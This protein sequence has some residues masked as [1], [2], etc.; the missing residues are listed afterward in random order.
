M[1]LFCVGEKS[2]LCELACW[3]D[4][5]IDEISGIEK[6]LLL[7]AQRSRDDAQAMIA[8]KKEGV[9]QQIQKLLTSRENNAYV[10]LQKATTGSQDKEV[11]IGIVPCKAKLIW[12]QLSLQARP[13]MQGTTCTNKFLRMRSWHCPCVC[14]SA[15]I[16]HTLN[17]IWSS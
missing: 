5:G 15:L 6:D 4:K 1:L 14:C 10:A 2:N 7:K 8:L 16:V 17:R 13:H 11:I 9:V 3:Q 12:R